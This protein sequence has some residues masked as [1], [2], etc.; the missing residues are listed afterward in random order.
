MALGANAATLHHVAYGRARLGT[1]GQS[2]ESLLVDAGATCRGLLRRHHAHLGQGQRRVG[3]R[4]RAPRGG[5]RGDAAA[6]LRRRPRRPC[7]TKT[8]TTNRTARPPQV[9]RAAGIV[10]GSIDEAVASGV[11]RAFYPHGLGHSLGLQ[12]HDVG[13]ALRPARPGNAFLRNTS[14]IAAGQVFTIEPGIYFIADLLEPLRGSRAR[15]A[16][17]LERRRCARASRRRPHR[18]RPAR[19]RPRIDV[20]NLTREH[21]PS[22][23]GAV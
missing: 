13:C 12:T 6:A 5:G 1:D 10:R 17:R 16:R 19:R 23:G 20:R 2:A 11:T 3:E 21:L 7:R 8:C 18:R 9:L 14:D 15:S 22:G 4:V